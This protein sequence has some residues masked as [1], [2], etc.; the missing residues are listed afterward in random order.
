MADVHLGGGYACC[1]GSDAVGG[2]VWIT[3]K[4]RRTVSVWVE[5]RRDQA[6][7]V[8]DPGRGLQQRKA[9]GR[10]ATH[11]GENGEGVG[12][13]CRQAACVIWQRS[14]TTVCRYIPTLYVVV[15]RMTGHGVRHVWVSRRLAGT[16]RRRRG[17]MPDAAVCGEGECW[18]LPPRTDGASRSE[19]HDHSHRGSGRGAASTACVD[20]YY[21][22]HTIV[23]L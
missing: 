21:I 20:A 6:S 17:A 1:C 13:A 9:A 19:M 15:R 22:I 2:V 8:G 12:T 11:G 16:T 7:K 23:V 10:L 14:T 18:R 4:R 3:A 5:T